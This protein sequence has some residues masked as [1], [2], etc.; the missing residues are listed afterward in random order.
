MWLK[1]T[2]T[3]ARCF[4][5]ICGSPY[6]SGP[7]SRFLEFFTGKIAGIFAGY[8]AAD[9]FQ[10]SLSCEL[11]GLF[12]AFLM[13]HKSLWVAWKCSGILLPVKLDPTC[14]L[15]T[16]NK[17]RP[18]HTITNSFTMH[19]RRLL[20]QFASARKKVRSQNRRSHHGGL[21]RLVLVV[22]QWYLYKWWSND[23]YIRPFSLYLYSL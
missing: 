21:F 6:C 4:Y 9:P 16:S 5:G 11:S 17:V 2:V 19:A 18:F 8:L 22:E 3:S 20:T 15:Q 10:Y 12:L 7:P 13:W 23:I 14:S 1:K